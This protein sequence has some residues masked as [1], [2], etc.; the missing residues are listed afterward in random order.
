MRGGGRVL[1][2]HGQGQGFSFMGL[3][4][5]TRA[6]FGW[7]KG[8]LVVCSLILSELLILYGL[9]YRALGGISRV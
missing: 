3:F 2:V 9:G 4:K 6:Q 7:D 8:E 1:R 5:E